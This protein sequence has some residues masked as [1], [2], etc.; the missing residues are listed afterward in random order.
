VDHRH[1]SNAFAAARHASSTS[2]AEEFGA[3]AY[4]S[5]VDGLTISI[6]WP[7]AAGW[8]S[9]PMMLWMT[10]FSDMGITYSYQHHGGSIRPATLVSIPAVPSLGRLDSRILLKANAFSNHDR[11]RS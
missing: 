11:G 3:D 4:T 6:I 2:L 5:P 7:S 9:P 8:I 10:F 1:F